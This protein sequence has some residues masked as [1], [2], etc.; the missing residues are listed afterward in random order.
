MAAAWQEDVSVRTVV[1]EACTG[2]NPFFDVVKLPCEHDYCV[3]DMI[4]KS[5]E[6]GNVRRDGPSVVTGELMT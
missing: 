6:A 3:P 1:C 2:A 5:E 4:P